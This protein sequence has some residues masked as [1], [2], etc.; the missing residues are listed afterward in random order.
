MT[1]RR[2]EGWT[3][4]FTRSYDP[5]EDRLVIYRDDSSGQVGSLV[6]FLA[7]DVAPEVECAGIGEE[8]GHNVGLKLP[9]GVAA[10]IRAA[11]LEQDD[12]AAVL[13]QALRIERRRV[14]Q[15]I[16]ALAEALGISGQGAA[17]AAEEV[18]T[19]G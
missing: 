8:R 17:Q 15:L 4:V 1:S 10:A 11:V 18:G 14:D 7:D 3:A 12:R 5:P 13:E 2:T 19:D 6:R 9:K 16:G